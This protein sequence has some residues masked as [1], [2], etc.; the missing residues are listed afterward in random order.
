[1]GANCARGDENSVE[2]EL[3][4]QRSVVSV[5]TPEGEGVKLSIVGGN[6]HLGLDIDVGDGGSPV[7]V[8]ATRNLHCSDTECET[9][10]A[11]P[12]WDD[13]KITVTVSNLSTDG[14]SWLL[15]KV[16]EGLV[17]GLQADRK[18]VV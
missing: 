4:L 15:G 18:S 8:S 7:P 9:V 6:L 2:I 5:G 10:F 16:L 13:P 14:L 11:D 17:K 12:G 3:G 1:M